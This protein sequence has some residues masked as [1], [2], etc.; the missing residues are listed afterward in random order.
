MRKRQR[1]SSKD[2]QPGNDYVTERSGTQRTLFKVQRLDYYLTH[3]SPSTTQ[4]QFAS[5][6]APSLVFHPY[7][8]N[9]TAPPREGFGTGLLPYDASTLEEENDPFF[10]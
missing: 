4:S 8:P 5:S 6:N 1:H 9:E 3:L 7:A 10:P 2:T